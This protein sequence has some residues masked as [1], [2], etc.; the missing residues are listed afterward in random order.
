MRRICLLQRLI[1]AVRHVVARR[2]E[3]HIA[4]GLHDEGR[5]AEF[6]HKLFY[7]DGNILEG[8]MKAG[9]LH[10]GIVPGAC[11]LLDQAAVFFVILR[12]IPYFNCIAWL[13]RD[14]TAG[15]A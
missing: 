13:R 14:S 4:A 2:A 11:D 8:Q 12:M 3:I 10:H 9:V 15:R 5:E 6:N 1:Q 7:H